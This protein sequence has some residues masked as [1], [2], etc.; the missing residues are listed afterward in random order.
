MYVYICMHMYLRFLLGPWYVFIVCINVY[1]EN[2]QMDAPAFPYGMSC[3]CTHMFKMFTCTL[4]LRL[5]ALV[6]THICM[7]AH[8]WVVIYKCALHVYCTASHWYHL[9]L[10]RAQIYGFEC[11]AYTHIYIPWRTMSWA[12]APEL[13]FKAIN[14]WFWSAHRYFPTSGCLSSTAMCRQERPCCSALCVYVCV[15][16]Y[17]CTAISVCVYIY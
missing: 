15:W 5:T 13:F 9:S 16:V 3:I 10:L 2:V 6:C 12:V 11:T 14:F 1:V 8:K 17:V 7:H 4:L